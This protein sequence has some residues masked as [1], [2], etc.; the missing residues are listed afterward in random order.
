MGI[1]VGISCFSKT[2]RAYSGA[3]QGEANCLSRDRGFQILG[4]EG[5]SKFN[6]NS[7]LLL[8][9]SSSGRPLI[10]TLQELSGRVLNSTASTAELAVPV[11]EAQRHASAAELAIARANETSASGD[12]AKALEA[13]ATALSLKGT[14]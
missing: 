9:M 1:S 8:A 7:R 4:P 5:I 10:S 11:L 13:A 2:E 12:I 14:P 6:Q 3:G